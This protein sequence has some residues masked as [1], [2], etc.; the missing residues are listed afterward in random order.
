MRG[1]RFGISGIVFAALVAFAPALQAQQ[2]T[3]TGRVTNSETMAP[4]SQAQIEVLGGTQDTGTLSDNQGIYRIQL[5]AGTYDLRVTVVGYRSTRFDNVSVSAGGTT[6]LDMMLSSQAQEL[7]GIVV[8]ASRGTPEKE[9]ETVA[10]VHRVSSLE[11]EERP[12]PSLVEHLRSSPGVDIISHGVQASNVTVRGFNNIFSGALHM[13]TDHRLGGVPS[14]RVNLMHWIPTSEQD[15]DRMEVVL[16][17]GSALYGPNTAN[18]VVHILTKSPLDD[19]STSIVLGGGEQSLFQGQFR[20]GFK[21]TDN[22]AFK[23]SGQYLQ[24]E[25]WA[26]T[27]PTEAANRAAADANSTIC[28]GD[29]ASRGLSAADAQV[30]CSRLGARDF[31][32][33]RFGVEARADYQFAEDGR[34]VTTYG[35][36][37]A[38]GVELTGLGAGQTRDWVYEFFQARI[39][40]DRF[41]AQAYMNTSDA[42][43]SY[44]LRDGVQLADFSSLMVGQIQHG[45]SVADGK[46]DFTYGADFFGTRPD[47]RGAI[48][49]V[50]EDDDDMN[51]FGAYLQSKTALSDKV[52][53]VLAGR[54]DNHSILESNVFSPRAALVFKTGEQQSFRLSYNQAYSSP[55]SLNY[56][57]DIGGGF[58]PA[59]LGPLGYGTRA[60]GT[61]R[62]GWSLQNADGT[63]K[64]VK[65]PFNPNGAGQ[66]I[67]A[68]SAALWPMAV[69]VLAAQGAIDAQT[70]GLLGSLTPSNADIALMLL[71]TNTGALSPAAGAS[72]PA[73]TT[74]EESNTETFELG[75][76]GVLNQRVKITADVFYMKKNNF[77]SPLIVQTPLVL[78]NGQDVA[79]FITV[80]LVTAITQQ[81]MAGGLDAATAQAQAQAQA[82][83]LVP[84][85]AAGIA[86]IPLGV[87]SSPEIGG[88]ADLVATYR[89]VGDVDL[90]GA[91]FA[92]QAFLNDQFTLNAT[93]SHLSEDYFEIPDGAPIALNAPRHKGSMALAYRNTSSGLNAEGRVRFN[94]EFPAESAGFVGTKCLPGGGAGGLFDEDC[95]ESAAIFDFSMGYKV[96]STAATLQLAVTNLFNTDYRSFVGVPNV[97]RLAMVRVKYD[98]R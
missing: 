75:W 39:H 43:D 79:G 64:G 73:V 13:L 15:I 14:L 37:Q 24:G 22:F 53:L 20:S 86:Q 76:T 25:E 69:G 35:R 19:Q 46:Q 97:G 28:L 67:P 74:M 93:Y 1:K 54:I 7:D 80:P 62:N 8:S 49:G 94:N 68:A 33:E 16:G 9:T 55:S 59:P 72:L 52:D 2:G 58:A 65:S 83:V 77:V 96:P 98:I 85:L 44:L 42:G 45:L 34:L 56:F 51:E 63:L 41:F 40:A 26:Y 30:A 3:L 60:F 29:K 84:Q 4:I 95:V 71:D 10:T 32:I 18:G 17:P 48:N 66:L 91:D 5:A 11:I 27:D 87:A 88:G 31:D 78:L 47:T 89:N 92:M 38:S 57:L 82:G 61:G 6:T 12:A 70:A 90:W 21:L 23:V 50:Y 81:L 36:T